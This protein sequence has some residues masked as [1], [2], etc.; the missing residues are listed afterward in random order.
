MISVTEMKGVAKFVIQE[1]AGSEGVHWDLMLGSAQILETYRLGLPPADL[2]RTKATAVKIPDHPP[3][4]L[5]YEGSVQKGK[6]SVRI[7]ESGTYQV[8]SESDKVRQLQLSGKI[9]KG[10]CA[11][12]H[13][14]GDK[15]EL[16]FS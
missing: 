16:L 8:L 15:W 12:T 9:L 7:V 13:I 11:L 2:L 1:H 4:F 3:K 6:G 5:T 14:D 10:R